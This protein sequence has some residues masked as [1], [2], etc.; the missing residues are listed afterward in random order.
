MRRPRAPH[1]Q[2]CPSDTRTTAAAA[3][4]TPTAA[5]TGW[6]KYGVLFAAWTAALVSGAVVA[7]KCFG[8]GPE[9]QDTLKFRDPRKQIESSQ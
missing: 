7:I 2:L 1:W 4:T 9:V 5:A 6:N 8:P 3:A